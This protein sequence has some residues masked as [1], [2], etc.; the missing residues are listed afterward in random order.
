MSS[1]NNLDIV[2]NRFGFLLGLLNFQENLT[3]SD[4]QEIVDNLDKKA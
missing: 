2:I 1:Q 3:Q 4:K